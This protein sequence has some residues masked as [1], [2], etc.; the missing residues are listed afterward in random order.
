MTCYRSSFT[1]R[2]HAPLLFSLLFVMGC[3]YWVSLF[4][5]FSLVGTI[6]DF[7]FPPLA[8]GIALA[9]FRRTASIRHNLHRWLYR[10]ACFPLLLG[11]LAYAITA[12]VVCANL[13]GMMFI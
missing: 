11:G 4:T 6:L 10:A 2:R 9:A 5:D 3:W 7:L 1:M 8:A 12:I 13:F